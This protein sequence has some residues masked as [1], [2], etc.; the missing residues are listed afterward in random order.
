[1]L[2]VCESLLSVKA[3]LCKSLL[4]VKAAV[5]KKFLRLR[6]S[7]CKRLLCVKVCCVKVSLCVKASLRKSFCVCV[8]KMLAMW[9]RI[10]CKCF[11][12]ERLLCVSESLLCLKASLCES[13]QC[14]KTSGVK[15]LLCKTFSGSSLVVVLGSGWWKPRWH[16]RRDDMR[17]DE[18]G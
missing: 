14:V 1:M 6:V 9:K 12:R 17:R 8:C 7:V 15:K 5:C 10:V 11:V 13:S 3:S 2:S 4:C 16:M 18:L